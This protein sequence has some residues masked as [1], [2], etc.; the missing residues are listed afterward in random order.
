MKIAA[1]LAA[2]AMGSASM[3]AVTYNDAVNDLFDNGFA[4]IDIVNVTVSHTATTLTFDVQARGDLNATNWGKYCIG[5]NTGAANADTSNGWGRNI[6]WGGQAI[7]YWIGT[8]A[9]VGGEVR[10][11]TGANNNSNNLIDATY[12][13]G[14]QMTVTASGFHQIITFARSS[15]GMTGNGT[16]TFDV[17]TT[18]GGG[19]D[20]GVDHLSRSTPATSDRSVQSSS[21]QFL[22]YTIPTP[23]SLAL[24]GLGGLVA[25]RR[26][27]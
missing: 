9:D 22:S 3:A 24:L 15:I 26:R 19:G 14:T 11:M 8:W 7:N 2:M 1:L 5:I 23:G 13:S 27:R 18:G 4:H 16:F 25:G 17:I 21:G 6:S 12:N 10:Q 20:P